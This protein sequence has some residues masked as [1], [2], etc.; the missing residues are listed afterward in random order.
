MLRGIYSALAGLGVQQARLE[1]ISNNLANASTPGFK[2]Q[3]LEVEPFARYLLLA[4]GEGRGP[5]LPAVPR[6]LGEVA[7]GAAVTAV[8]TDWSPG[9]LQ[10]T[11]QYTDLAITGPGY[12]TVQVSDGSRTYQCY[13]RAGGFQ[14]NAQGYL[15]DRQGNLLLAEDGPVQV[16]QDKFTVYSDGTVETADGQRRKLLLVDFARPELLRKLGNNYYLTDQAPLPAQQPGIKQ[17]FLEKSN[18]DVVAQSAGLMELMRAYEAGQ[19]II[20]V[21]DELLHTAIN[22]IGVIK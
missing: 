17:G 18:V 7:Y 1:L 4:L 10:E 20:Q 6:K 21:H 11:G 13:T 16:G 5:G 8:H 12:F 19:R 15:E 3:Q 14:V 22:Q 9:L 2:Q